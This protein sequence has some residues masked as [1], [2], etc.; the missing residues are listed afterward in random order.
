MARSQSSS[1]YWQ[2]VG[3]ISGPSN[4]LNERW[5]LR[6]TADAPSWE[7]YDRRTRR[8]VA[9]GFKRMYL[10]RQAAEKAASAGF[11]VGHP[12]RVKY[13]GAGT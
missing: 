2:R 1:F 10:A 4:L 7:V 11:P 12:D 13:H 3:R 9:D 5:E 8:V 6:V